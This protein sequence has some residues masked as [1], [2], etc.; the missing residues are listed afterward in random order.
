METLQIGIVIS[1][2]HGL[3][4][5]HPSSL[6]RQP[7]HQAS[8]PRTRSGMHKTKPM[9]SQQGPR[10]G[11]PKTISPL[12]R[13]TQIDGLTKTMYRVIRSRYKSLKV[14]EM[15]SRSMKA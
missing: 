8:P 4:M 3:Q 7:T 12:I 13:K 2:S 10:E 1:S 14:I 11:F 6:P 9:L 15:G 5:M